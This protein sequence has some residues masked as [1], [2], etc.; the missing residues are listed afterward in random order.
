MNL[1]R[2]L[3]ATLFIVI[4]ALIGIFVASVIS[5]TWLVTCGILAAVLATLVLMVFAGDEKSAQLFFAE[6]WQ[7]LEEEGTPVIGLA[8][9]LI[10]LIWLVP[11]LC[12]FLSLLV[13]L[14]RRSGWF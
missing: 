14:L 2:G 10:S 3:K 11:L 1:K 5:A 4:Q 9:T 7:E 6:N 12:F 13:V 8:I